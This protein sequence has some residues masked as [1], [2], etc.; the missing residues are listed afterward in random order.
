MAMFSTGHFKNNVGVHQEECEPT[1]PWFKAN[2]PIK[3][4][5]TKDYSWVAMDETG[6]RET[7]AKFLAP[8]VVH[9]NKSMFIIKVCYYVHVVV[10]FGLFHRDIAMKLPFLMRRGP[11]VEDEKNL[12]P[13]K[14]ET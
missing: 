1:D 14:S 9:A 13:R 3:L 8:S 5:L 11:S 12:N 4:E 2:L 10:S 7:D 6:K